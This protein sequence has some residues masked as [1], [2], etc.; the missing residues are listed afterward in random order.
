MLLGDVRNNPRDTHDFVLPAAHDPEAMQYIGA[1]S[2]HS[3]G[4]ASPDQY[5]KWRTMADEFKLPLFVSEAGSGPREWH[6]D[7]YYGPYSWVDD[8]VHYQELFL[9]VHPQMIVYWEFSDDFSLIRSDW[10]TPPK[11]TLTPRYALQEHWLK[12]I[13]KGSEGLATTSDQK[14]VLFTAF[15]YKLA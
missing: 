8:M 6:G 9:Y 10:K 5:R 7:T 14:R 12:L 1:L 13:P 15:R 2:I 4:G 3:W 11:L